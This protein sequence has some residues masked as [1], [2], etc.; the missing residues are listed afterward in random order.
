MS[1][2][3]GPGNPYNAQPTPPRQPYGQ[4]QQHPTQPW[5]GFPQQPQQ[6]WG[7]PQ[8]PQPPYGWA[9]Q[10]GGPQPM[11]SSA[12]TARAMLYVL[13]CMWTLSGLL[14]LLVGVVL[15][16]VD[17]DTGLAAKYG[18]L[19]WVAGVLALALALVA[20]G[21]AAKYRTGGSGT[22][23]GSIV[24][25]AMSTLGLVSSLV[26]G[27]FLAVVPLVPSILLIVFA[28]KAETAAWFGRPQY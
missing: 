14:V 1:H 24:I 11:P 23:T 27:A 10:P 3:P 17:D 12:R 8:Q 20:V 22:R 28:A 9:G 18:G 6:H 13:A 21:V 19:L 25:G 7:G 5:Y 2:P 16:N 26:T 4:P 15:A